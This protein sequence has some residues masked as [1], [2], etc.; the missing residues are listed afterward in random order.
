MATARILTEIYHKLLEHFGEQ[1]WWPAKTPFEVIIGAILTQ[2]TNWS[3][4]QRAINNLKSANLL[5]PTKLYHCSLDELAEHIKPAGYFNIKARR[6]KAFIDWFFANYDGNLDRLFRKD[7]SVLRE[8]LLS[9]PGIGPETA[10]SI[11][12]YA[13]KKPTFVVD[14]YTYRIMHRHRFIPEETT[15]DELKRLFEEAFEPDTKV[16]NEF[17]ALLVRAGKTYCKKSQPLCAQCPLN[18]LVHN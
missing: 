10:D 15:Y 7:I 5:S 16:F 9:I 3:N 6:L 12:L 14:A 17:H 11:I 8:E 4:V 13:A 18:Y 1:Q 2:N